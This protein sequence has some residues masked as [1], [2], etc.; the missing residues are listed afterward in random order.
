MTLSFLPPTSPVMW[1][2]GF[3]KQAVSQLVLRGMPWGQIFHSFEHFPF[4]V[5]ENHYSKWP[6]KSSPESANGQYINKKPLFK[7]PL[8]FIGLLDFKMVGRR[9]YNSLSNSPK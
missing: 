7:G 9:T 8:H 6:K 4:T 2:P 5:V 3:V 1:P